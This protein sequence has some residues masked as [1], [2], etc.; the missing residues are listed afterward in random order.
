MQ[1][2]C[3]SS[4]S[5]ST[6]TIFELVASPR[7]PSCR[8]LTSC[9]CMNVTA[10]SSSSR[11]DFLNPKP[12]NAEADLPVAA[13]RDGRIQNRIGGWHDGISGAGKYKGTARR[14]LSKA[15][16]YRGPR[17]PTFFR[18]GSGSD[19]F[20]SVRYGLRR[21]ESSRRRRLTSA[22][23]KLQRRGFFFSFGQRRLRRREGRPTSSHSFTDEIRSC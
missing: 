14:M 15:L 18:L 16:Y 20:G 5:T 23:S 13:P 11:R 2:Y 7:L 12:R 19:R 21:I 17:S 9:A 1:C 4:T 3:G 10:S 22:D 8:P 6:S